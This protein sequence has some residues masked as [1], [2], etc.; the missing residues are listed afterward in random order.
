[1]VNHI[2]ECYR[3]AYY[4]SRD[5]NIEMATGLT[6]NDASDILSIPYDLDAVS[7]QLTDVIAIEAKKLF[8][9][10]QLTWRI[11]KNKDSFVAYG[12]DDK[13]PINLDGAVATIMM[14]SH[15]T[16]RFTSVSKIDD[17]HTI[18]EITAAE[19]K[20]DGHG[21]YILKR[22]HVTSPSESIGHR[23]FNSLSC[24][25]FDLIYGA[26]L[27]TS[28]MINDSANGNMVGIFQVGGNSHYDCINGQDSIPLTYTNNSVVFA[29]HYF[30]VKLTK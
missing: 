22:A 17:K 29:N 7:S 11:V 23:P 21:E 13:N 25:N 26:G 12:F 1:M 18:G 15:G 9:E 16:A 10:N 3:P 6:G 19:Y 4:P 28:R 24:S 27:I 2:I 14:D 5:A 20:K 30:P 8:S